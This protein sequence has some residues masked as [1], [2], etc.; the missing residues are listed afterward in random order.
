MVLIYAGKFGTVKTEENNAA[1]R[2]SQIRKA[3]EAV[4][5]FCS[6]HP[7]FQV[8]FPSSHLDKYSLVRIIKSTKQITI[9]SEFRLSKI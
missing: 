4:N 1:G 7:Y 6:K 3:Y 9:A 5:K 2:V 8:D